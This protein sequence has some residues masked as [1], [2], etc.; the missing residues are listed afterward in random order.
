MIKQQLENLQ[1][2]IHAQQVK[3][4]LGYSDKDHLTAAEQLDFETITYTE[5]GEFYKITFYGD[6]ED[7]FFHNPEQLASYEEEFEDEDEGF[8]YE[9]TAFGEL[10][11]IL[12]QYPEK[13]IALTF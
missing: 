13:I 3:S 5:I 12:I 11:E 1:K 4:A 8:S 7:H 10:I 2:R 9:H 6:G